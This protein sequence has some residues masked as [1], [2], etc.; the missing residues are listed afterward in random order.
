MELRALL[1]S[2]IAIKESL[3]MFGS[4]S[5]IVGIDGKNESSI[6]VESIFSSSPFM[7]RS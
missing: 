5:G 1:V 7:C 2:V 4:S 6:E 3:K